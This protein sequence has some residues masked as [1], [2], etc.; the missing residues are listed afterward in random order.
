MGLPC[1]MTCRLKCHGNINYEERYNLFQL[2]WNLENR[3]RKWDFLARYVKVSGTKQAI[4]L[5]EF[6]RRKFSRKYF[7][8]V[9]NKEIQ[10]CKKMFLNTFGISEK[11]VNTICKKLED[12]PTINADMTGKHKNRPHTIPCEVKQ[13]IREHINSFPVVD[14]HYTRNKTDKKY[15]EANLTISKMHR[16]YLEWINEKP[17]E[18][19]TKNATLRQYTDVFNEFNISFF[20]PKKD[21]CDVCEK[22]KIAEPKEKEEQQIQYDEHL[23]NKEVVRRIK[24]ADKERASIEPG[25]CVAVFDLEKVLT[26]PQ[27]ETSTF[28]YK[29]KFATYN[30]TIYDIG[31]REGFCYIWNESDAKR[32][33]NEIATCLYMFLKQ[34]KDDGIQEFSFYSDNCGGQN[35]NRFVFAMWE[36]AAYK[37][38]IKI[39]HRFLEKGHTQNEGDSMHATIEKTKKGKTI[40]VPAQWVTLVQCA[41]VKGAPYS[42]KEVSNKDF[43]D[44]K[45]IVNNSEYNWKL[46]SNGLLVKWS[47]VKEIMVTFEC[48]FQLSI[49]YNLNITD[50]TITIS[51]QNKKNRGRHQPH[52]GPVRAYD[53]P[54]PIEK[55]KLND[56][57]SLCNTGLIPTVY[58]AF[59]KSLSSSPASE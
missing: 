55:L 29:R 7:L 23:F 3:S 19:L 49:K 31:K 5:K 9:K 35:R 30:F 21:L 41:K 34:K 40:Y 15:L 53:K 4:V 12:S 57:L 26:T 17:V 1:P 44:F 54:F 33:A 56:L 58:H 14:S 8:I 6:S 10:V 2:Y 59:Y 13:F 27:G 25:F 22:Y 11:V 42:V 39:T 24:N 48:P 36:Y 45:H 28:Y 51:L 18:T 38:K 47:C 50:D 43:L 37:L 32:G 16:L 52:C 46:A 20:K